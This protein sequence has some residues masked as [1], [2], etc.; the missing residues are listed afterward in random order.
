MAL[1]RHYIEQTLT[2]DKELLEECLKIQTALIK[3]DY[4]TA[5]TIGSRSLQRPTITL[6]QIRGIIKDLLDEIED[7]EA[8]LEAIDAGRCRKPR[9]AFGIVPR[10]W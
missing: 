4:V 5:Y 6:P 2:V 7:L 10:D 1:K 9:K 8:Q 3:G